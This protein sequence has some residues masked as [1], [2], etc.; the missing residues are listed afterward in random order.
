M[1]QSV[2][3]A[4]TITRI[5]EQADIQT[6]DQANS[7]YPDARLLVLVN[8]AYRAL[9]DLITD[10]LPEVGEAFFATS[11]SVGP[12]TWTLP[13]AFYRELG[14]DFSPLGIVQNATYFNFLDRN[15]NPLRPALVPRY[16]I[17]NGTIVW[18]TTPPSAAVTLWYIPTPTD[19]ASNGSFDA[20]NGWDDYVVYW[21]VREIRIKQELDLGDVNGR[22]GEAANRIRRACKRIVSYSDTIG[23]VETMVDDAY[24]NS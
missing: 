2:T 23:D 17:R 12:S 13:A 6:N 21:V 9:F 19:M 14:I 8:D 16:R 7:I 15:R 11:A 10:T 18:D 24:Y 3:A 1:A 4:A 5:R 20:Y 22:L